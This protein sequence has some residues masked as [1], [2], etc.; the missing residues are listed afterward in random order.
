MG[1]LDV[2]DCADRGT[3][4]ERG[5]RW[6][7]GFEG[8]IDQILESGYAVFLEA[9]EAQIKIDRPGAVD[10]VCDFRG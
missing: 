2:D 5:R 1:A 9:A 4:V 8:E 10:D 3:E 6:S 7:L